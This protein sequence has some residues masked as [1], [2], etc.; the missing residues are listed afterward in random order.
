MKK[1]LIV[2]DHRQIVDVLEKYLQ[3]AGFETLAVYD[4]AQAVATFQANQIDLILLDIMLPNVSGLEICQKIRESSTVPIIMITAKNS[5]LDR[6]LGLE[7]GADDYIVKP[8]SPKEVVAR[9][10]ALLR[11][12]A[13]E[14]TSQS[15][16]HLGELE[17]N[18][19]AR[20]IKGKG[21]VLKL[22][23]KEF[24][25]LALFMQY[26]NQVFSR[27]HLLDTV[28][29]FDYFGDARTVDSHVKRLRAKLR[30]GEIES[31]QIVT[32]WG[33]GYL[34]ECQV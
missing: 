33:E 3:Q 11:R 18:L 2:E 21:E 29:G 32:R 5:D 25:L 17:L 24:D 8:F 23:K 1:I 30:N 4:G 9:V 31:C 26:P 16:L 19:E 6:I 15:M 28:W 7:I 14:N 22:T 34:L 10:N 12:V 13:F 27:E 20:E